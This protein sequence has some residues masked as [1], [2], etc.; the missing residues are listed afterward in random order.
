MTQNSIDYL[1]KS[2]LLYDTYLTPKE[3]PPI[4]YTPQ[5]IAEIAARISHPLPLAYTQYLAWAGKLPKLAYS[6]EIPTPARYSTAILFRGP[7][8]KRWPSTL[9]AM[10][11]SEGF[12][13]NQPT[14]LWFFLPSID[15]DPPVYF[16][17]TPSVIMHLGRLTT[18]L[19][20]RI[21]RLA[22]PQPHRSNSGIFLLG[23]VIGVTPRDLLYQ[24]TYQLRR[25]PI[26]L[27]DLIVQQGG[28]LGNND[29]WQKNQVIVLGERDF[30]RAYINRSVEI[31]Q[32]YGFTCNYI[33]ETDF[34]Y[35]FHFGALPDYSQAPK[36]IKEHAGLAYLN[37]I[38]FTWPT[39]DPI[40]A[41]L[42]GQAE[43][44]L[45]D[46]HPLF[47]VYH[48]N[49]QKH[50]S[51]HD[52]RLALRRAIHEEALG[53]RAVAYHLAFLIRTNRRRSPMQRAVD[54]WLNDLNWLRTTFYDATIHTFIWPTSD[55]TLA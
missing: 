12:N 8:T 27:P 38:G 24:D 49:V 1:A 52:R 39:I 34:L 50:T 19:E 40:A 47:S 46:E 13:P 43:F 7:H 3:G 29:I 31:G 25:Q 10:S 26:L 15:D 6:H 55:D 23:E 28:I 32:H 14:V 21:R 9:L 54:L 16:S 44:A 18:Y 42:Q 33:T 45:A 11:F 22:G 20:N 48:Y 35:Y 53:L 37:S 36:R 30:D 51:L 5:E 41:T 4:G 2:K 17:V